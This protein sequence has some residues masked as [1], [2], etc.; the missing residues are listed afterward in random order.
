[1][2]IRISKKIQWDKNKVHKYLFRIGTATGCHQD[3]NK[4]FFIK[5]YQV[6]LCARCCGIWAGY[7]FG[8]ISVKFI[9]MP[10]ILCILMLIIMFYDW[11]IQNLTIRD[12]TN[13]RRFVTGVCYGVA[14]IQL[15]YK[16]LCSLSGKID[17]ARFPL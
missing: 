16:F 17:I 10:I 2:N 9:N 3:P 5:G 14:I 4:S 8:L 12:S 13:L 7:T 1:M 15:L 11:Y 6:P